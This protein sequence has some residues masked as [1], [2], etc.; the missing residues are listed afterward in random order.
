M[1]NFGK[2]LIQKG[3]SFFIVKEKKNSNLIPVQSF[4]KIQ[5]TKLWM[6]KSFFIEQQTKRLKV[7]VEANNVI[8]NIY[9]K[10]ITS[11]A[12]TYKSNENKIEFG[13]IPKFIVL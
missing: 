2:Y 5:M 9:Y 7:K 10:D 12:F 13:L 11:Q 3:I 1:V 4:T 6:I 8:K